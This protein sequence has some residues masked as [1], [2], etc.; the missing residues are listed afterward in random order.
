MVPI[1]VEIQKR[2]ILVW[3]V[4]ELL[5]FE[6]EQSI[7]VYESVQQL[8]QGISIKPALS[9]QSHDIR[10]IPINA[11]PWTEIERPLQ[12]TAIKCANKDICGADTICNLLLSCRSGKRST[13]S[14]LL[15]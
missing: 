3:N 9:V 11:D 13:L 5:A 2:R 8:L 1:D 12:T 7:A 6:S 4:E 10:S 15:G 14:I